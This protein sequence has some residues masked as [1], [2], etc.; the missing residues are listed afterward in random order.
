MSGP[1]FYTSPQWRALR[2][3]HLRRQPRCVVCGRAAEHV[4]HIANI[5]G[6]PHRRLDPFNL[7]SLCHA[8]HSILTK[9]YD[10]GSIAG[11]CDADGNTLDPSHPWAAGSNA[12][13]I[14]AANAPK[15]PADPSLPA[16]LKRQA[17]R[18]APRRLR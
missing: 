4:D 3:Q 10:A 17:V 11:A 9:A 6:A 13:A 16:R 14:V 15:R 7:Q 8:H 1:A 12:E 18:G 5:K 2:K